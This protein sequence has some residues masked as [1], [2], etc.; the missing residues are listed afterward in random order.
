MAGATVAG[1]Q[2]ALAELVPHLGTDT[3][4]AAGALLIVNPGEAGAAGA[5]EAIEA[6]E[7]IGL[8]ERAEGFALDGKLG[9]FA[10]EVG[11]AKGDAGAGLVEGGGERLDLERAA[12]SAASWA[13][14]RSRLT[15]S[16]FSG[17]HSCPVFV[18]GN[19]FER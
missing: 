19:R 16:S 17:A 5:A 18:R 2:F 7:H 14:V 9:Q 10:V 1:E 12:A 8:D 13:S 15:N 4:A 3:H 6:D 11:L